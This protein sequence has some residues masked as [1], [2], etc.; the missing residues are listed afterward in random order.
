MLDALHVTYSSMQGGAGR[1]AS[2]IFEA[3][4]DAGVR[5]S[6]LTADRL[7]LDAGFASIDFGERGWWAPERVVSSGYRRLLTRDK[8]LRSFGLVRGKALERI[9]ALSPK[10]VNLHWVNNGTLAISDIA[11]IPCPVVWTLHDEWPASG[12]LHYSGVSDGTAGS[13]PHAL[14]RFLNQW[15]LARKQRAWWRVRA[16][17]APSNWMAR[18]V[19]R[20]PLNGSRLVRVIPN[21]VSPEDFFPHQK[22]ES[23]RLLRL[24][25][26]RP[27]VGFFAAS[28]LRD[29]RKGFSYLER[30]LAC[31][32][33]GGTEVQLLVVGG[34][35]ARGATSSVP[36][37]YLD[38]VSR[39]AELRVLYSACDVIAVPSL[40]DNLPAVAQEAQMCGRPVAG[41]AVGGLTDIVA[42]G[43]SGY[44][45]ELGNIKDFAQALM[46]SIE[47]GNRRSSE[48]AIAR[49]ARTLWSPQVVGEAYMQLYS[50]AMSR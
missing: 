16:F 50:D 49:R 36:T 30:A 9:R 23:R 33:S 48:A 42:Q 43:Q 40:A 32:S 3:T 2:R 26:Q 46:A 6:L 4:L 20:S 18:Q 13:R 17:V 29:P 39:T 44:L 22:A 15:T 11:D 5:S 41:F 37:R 45:A 27:T 24:D 12:I 21:P 14:D 38:P 1:A 19:S 10:V 25:A 31:V 47:L 35:D 28:G 8:S 7:I 34:G